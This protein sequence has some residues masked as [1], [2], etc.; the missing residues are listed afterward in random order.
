M[1]HFTAMKFLCSFHAFQPMGFWIWHYWKKYWS[2][3]KNQS[4]LM[5]HSDKFLNHAFLK[6][7]LHAVLL[8]NSDI[9]KQVYNMQQWHQAMMV[10][11]RAVA[12][13]TV[14]H[15]IDCDHNSKK[16]FACAMSISIA[17][18]KGTNMKVSSQGVVGC[19]AVQLVANSCCCTPWL[20]KINVLKLP[21]TLL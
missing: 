8:L 6:I 5:G 1:V 11:A 4:Y 14:E 16:Q 9:Q 19:G 10:R 15:P 12:L 18:N 21:S 2:N 7:T 20:N 13:A 17:I 3:T